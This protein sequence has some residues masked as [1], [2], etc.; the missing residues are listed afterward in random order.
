MARPPSIDRSVLLSLAEQIVI[1]RGA[2]ALTISALAEAASISK[3]GVQSCFASK[4]LIIQ[5]MLSRWFDSENE[6]FEAALGDVSTIVDRAR[7][8]AIVT[9]DGGK[10]NAKAASLLIALFQSPQCLD[11]CRVWYKKRFKGLERNYESNPKV[12]L[13]FLAIEG[14]YTLHHF[15]LYKMKSAMWTKAFEEIEKLLE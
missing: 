3:G 9:R 7:A 2:A 1:D 14:A 10:E 15:G 8:H 4:E 12:L 11:I 5:T 6:R 13:A